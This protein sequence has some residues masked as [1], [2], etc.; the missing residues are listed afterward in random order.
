MRVIRVEVIWREGVA[1]AR[2]NSDLLLENLPLSELFALIGIRFILIFWR[3]VTCVRRKRRM[4][5]FWR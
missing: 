1:V 2:N 3:I 5:L 4:R